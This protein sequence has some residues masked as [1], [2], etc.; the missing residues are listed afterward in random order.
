MPRYP[1]QRTGLARLTSPKG[2][3]PRR[4][5]I[6]GRPCRRV[7]GERGCR[8]SFPSGARCIC[9]RMPT[10]AAC[11]GPDAE[12]VPSGGLSPVGRG[13]VGGPGSCVC[14][15]KG[16]RPRPAIAHSAR[17]L[18]WA[19]A[20]SVTRPPPETPGVCRMAVGQGAVSA[21]RARMSSR[22]RSAVLAVAPGSRSAPLG[23]RRAQPHR[24]ASDFMVDRLVGLFC[25]HGWKARSIDRSRSKSA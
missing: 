18:P 9:W 10:L 24:A 19:P 8:S 14:A 22:P 3:P 25:R 15:P 21:R 1:P 17:T 6:G 23:L 2:D 7:P 5:A 20:W 11:I 13:W 4:R 12:N 16:R